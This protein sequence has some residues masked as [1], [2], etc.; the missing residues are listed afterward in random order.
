MQTS[1]WARGA[2]RGARTAGWVAG[3]AAL[4]TAVGLL[5]AHAGPMFDD[6]LPVR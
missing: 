2:A 4:S 3:I 1:M 5:G 6:G